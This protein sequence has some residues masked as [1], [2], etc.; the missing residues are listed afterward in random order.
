MCG[1][2]GIISSRHDD[3]SLQHVLKDMLDAIYHRGPDDEGAYI[4]NGIGIGMR[5][6]SIIDVSGGHQPIFNEDDTI[7]DW[8][9]AII[10]LLQWTDTGFFIRNKI[11]T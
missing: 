8:N 4:D 5:R 9:K 7:Q 10:L 11:N 1:I 3:I 2:A 6:L